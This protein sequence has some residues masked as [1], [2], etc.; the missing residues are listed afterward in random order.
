MSDDNS[1]EPLSVEEDNERVMCI[2]CRSVAPCNEMEA[3]IDVLGTAEVDGEDIPHEV[4]RHYLCSQEC[5]TE[6]AQDAV[7]AMA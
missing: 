1:L 4:K 5:A 6:F 2:K 7:G 3:T